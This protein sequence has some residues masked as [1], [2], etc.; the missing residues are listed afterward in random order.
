MTESNTPEA[1]MR[2]AVANAKARDEWAVIV[3]PIEEGRGVRSLLERT[4]GL[5]MRLHW[6]D[7]DTD[8]D[9]FVDGVVVGCS[10]ESV[11]VQP[12]DTGSEDT[13]RHESEVEISWADLTVVEVY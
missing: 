1:L 6:H 3:K 2:R 10:N 13:L 9:R 8:A 4:G 11:Q 7:A 5:V 12:V